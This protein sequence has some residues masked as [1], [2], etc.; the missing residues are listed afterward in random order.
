M[1]FRNPVR[2]VAGVPTSLDTG[3]PELG[4]PGVTVDRGGIE[5]R[6]LLGAIPA[7]L[8]AVAYEYDLD[9]PNG[10]LGQAGSRLRLKGFD[11]NAVTSPSLDLAVQEAPGG[12]YESVAMI[13]AG[14]VEVGGVRLVNLG[15]PT[16]AGDAAPA[17]YVDSRRALGQSTS[18]GSG[19]VS[20]ATAVHAI[21]VTIPDGLPSTARIKVEGRVWVSTG[22]G[23]G[24][25]V[26]LSSTAGWGSAT[27]PVNVAAQTLDMSI[28]GYDSDLTPGPRTYRVMVSPT[29]PGSISWRVPQILVEV[30]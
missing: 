15:A 28:S 25:N 5:W 7:G 9:P 19:S 1:G 29:A 4:I 11:S 12:G 6:S 26:S 2:T 21:T 3:D 23:V 18:G 30:S 17:G 8:T 22:A 27:R 10:V 14:R 24:P 13:S 16:A 20:A